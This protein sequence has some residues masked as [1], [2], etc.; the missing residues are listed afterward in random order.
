MTTWKYTAIAA[1]LAA[2]FPLSAAARV[3]PSC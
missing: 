2:T 3:R 1:A